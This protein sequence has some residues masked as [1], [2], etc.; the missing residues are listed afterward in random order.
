VPKTQW[1][2]DRHI[3]FAFVREQLKDSYS[4]GGRPSINPEL[5]LRIL[6][7]AYLLRRQ[8][9]KLVEKLRICLLLFPDWVHATL[10]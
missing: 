8:Q 4:D 2:I 6:L 10:I 5:L 3:N 7:I 1:L 9:R